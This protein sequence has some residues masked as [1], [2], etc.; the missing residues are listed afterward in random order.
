MSKRTPK[1][2]T[3]PIRIRRSVYYALTAESERTGIPAVDLA[4]RAI[5]TQL[6]AGHESRTAGGAGYVAEVT[7]E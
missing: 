1:E 4:S 6:A 5:A 7:Q 2:P 3:E